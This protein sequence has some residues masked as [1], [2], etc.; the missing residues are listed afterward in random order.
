MSRLIWNHEY[1]RRDLLRL[2]MAHALGSSFSCWF[3]PLALAAATGRAGRACILL[4]MNGGPSQTDTFD[5]KPEHENGGPVKA[6]ETAVP[7][8][9]ISEYL[10]GVAQQMKDLAIIRSMT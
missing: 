4:W 5:P 3:P 9:H 7:G 10:P 2:S 1:N 6:I 8:I